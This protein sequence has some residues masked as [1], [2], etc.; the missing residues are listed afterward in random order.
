MEGENLLY[1]IS[2][3]D[4]GLA[5]CCYSAQRKLLFQLKCAVCLVLS[6]FL[7]LSLL[8]KI[9][10]H[11]CREKYGQNI[12]SFCLQIVFFKN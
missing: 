5:S 1:F 6:L 7:S 4:G 9:D 2:F 10:T 12:M 8:Q 3:K 11:T